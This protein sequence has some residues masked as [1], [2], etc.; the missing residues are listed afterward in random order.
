MFNFSQDHNASCL[1]HYIAIVFDFPW[2]CNTQEKLETMVMQNF[3][4]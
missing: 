4:G 3:V 2:G 1:P